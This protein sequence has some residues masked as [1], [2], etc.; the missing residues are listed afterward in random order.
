MKSGYTAGHTSELL[1]VADPPALARE[2]AAQFIRIAEE[3]MARAGRFIVALAGGSTPMRLYSL[4]PAE[5]YRTRVPWQQTCVFWGDE[6]AVPPEHPDSNFG[7]A[8]AALLSRVPIPANQV[9]RMEAERADLDTAA[10]DYEA[11]IA[12]T[13]AVQPSGAPPVFDL[14][15][16][17]LGIDGHT[18]SLFPY[19]HALRETMRWVVPN[20]ISTRRVNRLTLTPPILNRAGTILFLVSDR[21]KASIL[22]EVLQGPA[23]PERLPAQLIR[24]PAGRLMWLVDQA[25][26]SRLGERIP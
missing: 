9:H 3:A 10:H 5:P 12:R 4:L 6:R 19:T 24:P 15:L 2:A 21:D 16:L 22:Q 20:Y 18:A 1:V 26:A 14:I 23:D 11:E 8:Q 13:F 25:A 17:G 7:M